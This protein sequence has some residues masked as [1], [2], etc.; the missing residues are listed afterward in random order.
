MAA[1]PPGEV[2]TLLAAIDAGSEEAK[3]KLFTLVYQE[4]H[5]VAGGLMRPERPDHTL[6]PTAL[7][8]EA[9]FKLFGEQ[10]LRA[11]N[12]GHFFAAAA[13]AMRQV[14]VDHARKRKAKKRPDGL[15]RV[16]LDDVLDWLESTQVEMLDLDEA[17]KALERRSTRQHEVV[18]LRFFGGLKNKEIATYLNVSLATV[19]KDWQVAR[20]WLYAELKGDEQ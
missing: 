11:S 7:V 10:K 15:S 2:T 6:Q 14:L 3:A 1:A 4:L 20:A 5:R 16:P 13:N 18:V 12:R 19:E 8:H 9:Y 17:L